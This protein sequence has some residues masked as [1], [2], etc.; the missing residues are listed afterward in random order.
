[1]L[2][3]HCLFLPEYLLSKI[4]KKKMNIF[5]LF[6]TSA[7]SSQAG[8]R[9]EKSKNV[10]CNRAIFFCGSSINFQALW[11]PSFQNAAPFKPY[12][13]L[14]PFVQPF[15]MPEVTSSRHSANTSF[16]V[17]F[18]QPNYIPWKPLV[19]WELEV[20]LWA[21]LKIVFGIVMVY[22]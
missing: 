18:I 19:K 10:W 11:L 1:M 9:K 12:I 7:K 4:L 8:N 6:F 2:V 16:N 3:F 20:N 5:H 13:T 17:T 14:P 15:I 22:V 21:S